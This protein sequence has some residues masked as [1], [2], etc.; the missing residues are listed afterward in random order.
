LSA[1]VAYLIL[2]FT[3]TDGS[4]KFATI[5]ARVLKVVFAYKGRGKVAEPDLV[6]GGADE[7]RGRAGGG[8]RLEDGPPDRQD[9]HSVPVR[10]S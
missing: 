9:A 3:S 5:K 1:V 8:G 10:I 7:K 6:D 2:L 4:E